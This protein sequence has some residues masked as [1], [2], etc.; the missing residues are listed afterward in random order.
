VRPQR[1][2]QLVGAAGPATV[3]HE[4]GEREPPLPAA[5]LPVTAFARELDTEVA[6]EVDAP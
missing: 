1:L 2:E 3:Q 5:K 4:V 6:A